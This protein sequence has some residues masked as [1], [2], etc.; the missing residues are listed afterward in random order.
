MEKE[1]TAYKGCFICGSENPIGLNLKFFSDGETT[2]T[3]YKPDLHHEG[4]KGIIHGGI[5]A[6]ILDEVMIKAT[7]ALDIR[8]LTAS[9][10]VRFKNPALVDDE[11]QFE[12]KITE[13][14]GRLISTSGKATTAMG[15]V[16]AEAT[17]KYLV[18]SSELDQKLQQSL[19]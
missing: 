17:G 3:T 10:E 13:R 11:F 4:W 19:E 15:T 18:P 12:G 16:I 7:L 8:C 1:V 5:I 14:K 9:M 6:A 2:R